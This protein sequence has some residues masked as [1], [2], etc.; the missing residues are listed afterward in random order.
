MDVDADN[1]PH[2]AFLI[3]EPP[4][5]SQWNVWY[6]RGL[7]GPLEKVNAETLH[8]A[9]VVILLRVDSRGI[10]HVVYN[11]TFED[12]PGVERVCYA[13]RLATPAGSGAWERQEPIPQNDIWDGI[14]M[15]I[16]IDAQD[17]IHLIVHHNGP[18]YT[19]MYEPNLGEQDAFLMSQ[20]GPNGR[21]NL[22]TGNYEHTLPVFSSRGAGFAASASLV[23]NSQEAEPGFVGPGWATNYELSIVDCAGAFKQPGVRPTAEPDKPID[24]QQVPNAPVIILRMGDGRRIVFRDPDHNGLYLA[25]PGYAYMGTIL[26]QPAAIFQPP[27]GYV[28]TTKFG[29]EYHFDAFGRLAK[30]Q[31][32]RP[33]VK[34][35]FTYGPNDSSA[36]GETLGGRLERN[37]VKITDTMGRKTDFEYTGDNRISLIRDPADTEY[38]LAHGAQG[39]LKVQF[40]LG[41]AWSY[42]YHAQTDTAAYM[43]RGLLGRV[44]T[45]RGT[46]E[47]YSWDLQWWPDGRLAGVKDPQETHVADASDDLLALRTGCRS[48][49]RSLRGP[50]RRRRSW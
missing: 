47:N 26:R 40:P 13:R 43:R 30:I 39:L 32:L 25:D 11:T 5:S 3:E 37:L 10:P 14:P 29:V 48:T 42:E 18:N 4:D 8:G 28:L 2:F 7:L 50:Q 19:R 41:V 12:L 17:R 49:I 27:A 36:F 45:P 33:Q 38:T 1:V 16:A 23:Y 15:G 46:A 9:A 20:A 34:M 31:D 24:S 6:R 21:V 44:R 35:E 22:A